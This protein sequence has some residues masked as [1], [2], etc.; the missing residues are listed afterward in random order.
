MLIHLIDAQQEFVVGI[1][2]LP[3]D[4]GEVL[5][6]DYHTSPCQV[7]SVQYPFIIQPQIVD[8]QLGTDW[9]GPWS[10]YDLEVFTE[11]LEAY[12]AFLDLEKAYDK[13]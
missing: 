5:C 12:A 13:G 9:P 6:K 11:K 8:E 1:N 4:T 3:H 2:S 7:S 10:N